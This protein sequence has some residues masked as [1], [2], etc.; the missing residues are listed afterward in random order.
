MKGIPSVYTNSHSAGSAKKAL[1]KAISISPSCDE[2]FLEKTS[3][4]ERKIAQST[5][6]TN[7]I[8][9]LPPGD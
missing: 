6:Y 5:A 1:P 2:N 4:R 3:D 8:F 9:N 7:Q